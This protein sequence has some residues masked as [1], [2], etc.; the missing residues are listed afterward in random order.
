MKIEDLQKSPFKFKAFLF[1]SLIGVVILWTIN[2]YILPMFFGVSVSLSKTLTDVFNNLTAL[3]ISGTIGILFL[4]LLTPKIMSKAEIVKL[5]PRDLKNSLEEILKDA[6]FYYYCGHT[7]RWTRTVTLPKLYKDAWSKKI[8]K[9]INITILDPNN[10]E[11]L[12]YF[13]SFGHGKREKGNTINDTKDL[14]KEL[15]S[16]ILI[17]LVCDNKSFIKVNLYL[18]SKVSL[19]R[20]DLSDKAAILTK[21][22]PLDPALKVYSGTFFYQSYKEEIKIT[23]DQSRKLNFDK[24]M[25]SDT[26]ITIERVKG[27]FQELDLCIGGLD[28][29]DLNWIILNTKKSESP[30]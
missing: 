23:Q 11:L 8:T 26:E 25:L 7:A 10:A 18:S 12:R 14:K 6:D 13:I 28:D 16:T 29:N 2:F 22:N 17:G 1:L 30:Y 4:Y 21:P 5:E 19:F 15:L 9:E 24:L 27:I 20:F 3:L